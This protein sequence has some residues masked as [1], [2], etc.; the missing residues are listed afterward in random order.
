MDKNLLEKNTEL[1]NQE[2]HLRLTWRVLAK[3]AKEV[4]YLAGPMVAVNSSTF[5]LQTIS[6]MMVG[7]LGELAQSSTAVSISLCGVTGFSFIFGMAS[8]LETLCG[9]AYGAKQYK[10]FGVQFQTGTFCVIVCCVPFC[11][12]WLYLGRLLVLV[13]QDPIIAH[14]AGKFAVCL[15][16]ALFGYAILQALIRYYLMQSLITPLILSS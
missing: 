13:G 9:Q 4:C 11:V 1:V 2:D 15:I 7:H 12:L 6:L 5:F 16:P 14:E 10:K 8:A 3:E